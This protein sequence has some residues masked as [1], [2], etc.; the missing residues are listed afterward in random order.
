M[1][2]KSY[3]E[4]VRDLVLD[5][6]WSLWAEIGAGGWDRRHASTAIDVEPLILATNHAR[7]QQLDR[8]LLEQA[9]NWSITNVRIVS[10]VRLRNL[11]KTL[12]PPQAESFG[13]F[14]A[15][16]RREANANWPG[17]GPVLRAGSTVSP[18][19]ARRQPVPDLTRP[20]LVQLRLRAAWG[21]SARAEII[22]LLLG[23]P[24][25]FWSVSEL[26]ADAAYGRDNV[27]DAVEMMARAGIVRE[28]GIGGS[29][30][31]QLAKRD[32]QLMSDRDPWVALLGP[33]PETFPNWAARFRLMLAIL[34]FAYTD[35]PN[36]MVRAA[37][38]T[39]FRRE[40]ATEIARNRVVLA[41]GQPGPFGEEPNKDF[42]EQSLRLLHDWSGRAEDQTP[43]V[44][45]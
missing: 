26:A 15:T 20:S 2:P 23:E 35:F 34:D 7:L 10:A 28:R 17:D 38:I 18:F 6:L 33:L 45:G 39:R 9:L 5:T 1:L 21:V 4:E 29:R 3:R 22:R 25:S 31:Y 42:E 14:A 36:P 43:A 8:R 40:H 41:I 16:V 19:Q 37:E 13:A 24:S 11:L 27:A 32:P 44:D 30:R 12:P